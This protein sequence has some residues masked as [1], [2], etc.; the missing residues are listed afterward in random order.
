MKGSFMNTLISA[1]P[2]HAYAYAPKRRLSIQMNWMLIALTAVMMSAEPAATIS[3][4]A[5]DPLSIRQGDFSSIAFVAEPERTPG[6]NLPVPY[7]FTQT[8]TTPP[9]MKFESYPCNRP[10]QKACSQLASANG[11]FLNGAPTKTGSYS[12]V[13]TAN[14]GMNEASQR[15]TVVVN[16]PDIDRPGTPHGQ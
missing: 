14:D 2:D 12:F 9:G 10:E 3:I 1:D 15:F 4:H 5:R 11:V 7:R 16:P 8:G 13:I 6:N